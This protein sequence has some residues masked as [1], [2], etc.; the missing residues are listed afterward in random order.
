MLY[1][2]NTNLAGE[3]VTKAKIV[4]SFWENRWGTKSQVNE[5]TKKDRNC[6]PAMLH[7][8]EVRCFILKFEMSK[9]P[10]IETVS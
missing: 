4:P 6:E 8:L 5:T 2:Y 3:D 9:S 7:F 10:D 1:C